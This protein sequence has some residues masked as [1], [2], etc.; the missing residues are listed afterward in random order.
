MWFNRKQKNKRNSR[1]HVLDVKLRSDQVRAS[2]LRLAAL[3]FGVVF[4]TTFGIYV[5][6]RT[7]QWAMNRLVYENTAFAIQAVEAQTDGVIS[8]DQIRRWANVKPGENLFA[9]DLARVKRDLE[10]VPH[11]GFASVERV[12][13][14]T[15]RIR[16]SEREPAAQMN[17]PRT[18]GRGVVE[19]AVFHIDPD[20][21]VMLPLDPRQR[22]TPPGASDE[23]LPVLTG[24]GLHEL[25]PGRRLDMPSVQAAM[26]LI[27]EFAHSPMAGMVDLKRIDVGSPEVLVVTTGQGSEVTFGL[28]D[29][30][31][32]MRRWREIHDQGQRMGKSLASL[33]LAVSNSIPARWLQV[34]LGPVNSPKA[35]KPLRTK[36]R[37]V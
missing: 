22:T 23:P 17:V 25:Q 5:L 33:D 16:V 35:P 15:L 24:V 27:T 28:S 31:R 12:L 7:G 11:V 20:G 2:R 9:L 21:F 13:P 6:W 26:R 37:N 3:A 32:Q 19:V 1:G 18:N 14:H 10:M 36:R 4:G 29:L 8:P 34:S 30:D